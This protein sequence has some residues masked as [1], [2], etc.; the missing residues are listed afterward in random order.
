MVYREICG[1]HV[2]IIR[3]NVDTMRRE[4]SI[5]GEI[6]VSVSADVI[7]QKVLSHLRRRY[8]ASWMRQPW[9]FF[10]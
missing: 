7:E 1:G 3:D 8:Y 5:D 2:T 9:G 6:V 4:Y 10:R